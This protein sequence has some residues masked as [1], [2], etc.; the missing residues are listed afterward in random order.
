MNV[1][2]VTIGD[3]LLLGFTIDTNAAHLARQLASIG[4]QIIRRQT[5]GD[6]A[7]EIAAAVREALERTGAVITTG[8]LG[9]T[10]DDMTKESIAAIFDRPMEQH[11]AIIDALKARWK[12]WGRSGDL[13]RS[14]YQQAMIPAGARILAN[15]HGTAPGIWLEDERGRWVAM[16][17]GVPREMRGMLADELLPLMRARVTGDPTVI[18]SRTLR[19][20]GVGES[21][22][23]D[24]L[25]LL[26]K[27]PEGVGL[28]YLPG[29]EGV[30]LRLTS[31]G[32]TAADAAVALE[33]AGTALLEIV[34]PATYGE[35]DTDLAAV[36]LDALR[37]RG[38]MLDRKSTRL[39]SS[40]IP[41]SR[42][43]SSA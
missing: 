33:R 8:G 6:S 43:P 28:A 14:N 11:D 7:L 19:T 34:G 37:V 17:P 21:A 32:R 38:L 16:L 42:M 9:P 22:I 3:E 15:G 5:C 39:N 36:V 29:W 1:E 24:Q 23:A 18:V 41:L 10:S 30:D 25:G 4:V 27:N 13:P 31:R 40:H 2:I 35:G 26:A 20:T 12:A